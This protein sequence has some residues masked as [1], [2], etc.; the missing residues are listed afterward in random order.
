MRHRTFLA[1]L[2]GVSGHR[3]ECVTPSSPAPPSLVSSGRR[4]P[5]KHMWMWIEPLPR[6]QECP[7]P[8]RRDLGR[9]MGETGLPSWVSIHIYTSRVT[10]VFTST[11]PGARSFCSGVE[12]ATNCKYLVE[13]IDFWWRIWFRMPNQTYTKKQMSIIDSSWYDILV[14]WMVI[15]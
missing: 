11:S 12:P 6:Q 5:L 7:W 4:Y 9:H 8:L 10:A 3:C 15:I 13:I 1:R 2:I 14:T